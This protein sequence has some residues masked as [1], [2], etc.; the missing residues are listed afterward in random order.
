[1][2]NIFILSILLMSSSTFAEQDPLS[3]P[4]SWFESAHLKVRNNIRYLK[5][6]G[7]VR[8]HQLPPCFT[9]KE[10]LD[11]EW[12]E[13][14]VAEQWTKGYC[15]SVLEFGGGSGS[16][17][18]VIQM[19]IENRKNHVVIQPDHN[20]QMFGGISELAKN[21]ASCKMEFTEIDHILAKGEGVEVLKMVS[22]PFDC[23]VADCENCLVDE[24][25]KN[26]N[27]FENI[28]YI[29]VE[30]DDRKPLNA[31]TGPYD[32]LLAELKMTKLHSGDG[33]GGECE[34]EVWGRA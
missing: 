11:S 23:I 1:M 27:L 33:C 9:G 20:G 13:R 4:P 19:N 32:A 8:R 5:G 17:S 16:V 24:Y 26:P 18:A 21:K 15:Q 12:G 28:K 10:G 31:K 2:H 3:Q 6:K 30:R 29:Q 25:K 22:Q 7:P 14:I 34:T